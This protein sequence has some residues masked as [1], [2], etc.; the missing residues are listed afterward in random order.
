MAEST[1]LR[2]T[3]HAPKLE[4]YG[5]VEAITKGATSGTKLD[6]SFPIGTPFQDVTFS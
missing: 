6:A 1:E 3:Y 5:T 4:V 2:K